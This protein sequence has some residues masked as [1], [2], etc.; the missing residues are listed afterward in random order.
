MGEFPAMPMGPITDKRKIMDVLGDKSPDEIKAITAAFDA[1]YGKDHGNR[2]LEDVIESR[3]SGT[4]KSKVTDIFHRTDKADDAGRVHTAMEEMHQWFGGRSQANCEKDIRDT[5][6]TMNSTQ[7]AA[8]KQDYETRYHTKFDDDIAKDSK[9]TPETKAAIGIYEHGSENRTSKDTLA[10]ADLATKA[11]NLDMFQEAFRGA[12]TDARTQYMANG[13]DAK[14]KAAFSGIFSD[15]DVDKARDYVKEGHLDTTTNVKDN[16]GVFSSND[17]AIDT[18]INAMS[19]ADRDSYDR[20]KTIGATFPEYISH[21][22]GGRSFNQAAY[23]KLTPDQKTDY[24]KYRTLHDDLQSAGNPA[25]V[26]RWEDMISN[27]GET[28]VTKLA[29]HGGLWTDKVDKAL[30][31][32]EGMNKDDFN[33]LKTDANYRKEVDAA[34]ALNYSGDDL[35]RAEAELNAKLSATSF[36]KGGQTGGDRNVIQ[37][38]KDKDG[39]WN[40]DTKGMLSSVENMS[41]ADQAKY[42]TDANFKKM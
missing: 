8:F 9:M 25:K 24:D 37:E 39:F 38:I 40:P 42:R 34:L 36:D 15:S 26:A 19:Q 2:N 31:D 13:G 30:S 28:L 14:M 22:R 33:R 3:L 1:K 20:G 17:K 41:A 27:H 10:L 6:A 21:G 11:K 12:S 4:D 16:T 32:I 23:D 7:I 18:T 29:Q 35:K 5:L